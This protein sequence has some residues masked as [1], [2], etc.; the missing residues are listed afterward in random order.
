AGDQPDTSGV[1]AHYPASRSD[2]SFIVIAKGDDDLHMR[3][4]LSK[5]SFKSVGYYSCLIAGGHNEREFHVSI[6][7][8]YWL[9]PR[10]LL[11]RLRRPPGIQAPAGFECRH[12]HVE[13]RCPEH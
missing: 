7:C 6:C 9:W 8:F 11:G 13:C 2:G 5:E 12:H 1:T 4:V 3:M 10:Q